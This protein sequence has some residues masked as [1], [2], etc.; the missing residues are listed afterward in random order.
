VE[1]FDEAHGE[2]HMGYYKQANRVDRGHPS[3]LVESVV[4]MTHQGCRAPSPSEDQ[5][6]LGLAGL[7]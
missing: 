3:A 5:L 1:K 7:L 6:L 4:Q 2:A